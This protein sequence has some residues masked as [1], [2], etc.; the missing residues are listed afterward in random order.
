MGENDGQDSEA[1]ENSD[2]EEGRVD[3]G[4]LL[5]DGDA[6]VRELCGDFCGVGVG[7]DGGELLGLLVELA[8]EAGVRGG[9]LAEVAAQAFG[10]GG[11][12]VDD[13]AIGF[14]AGGLALEVAIGLGNEA[15]DV[16]NEF[17]Q[18]FRP[19]GWIV[20]AW[21]DAAGLTR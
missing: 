7:G 3:P 8:V 17:E 2:G 18:S 11:D 10:E 4:A 20:V 1:D 5:Q 14:L 15:D 19:H 21:L 12:G 13:A 6:G 16:R 9:D